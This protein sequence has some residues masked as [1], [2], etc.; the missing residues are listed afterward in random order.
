[1]RLVAGN[2]GGRAGLACSWTAGTPPQYSPF[3]RAEL[4]LLIA[5]QEW[6]GT[7]AECGLRTGGA[8][9]VCTVCLPLRC[10]E[11]RK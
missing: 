2:E 1:V 5:Q 8:L 6:L 10:T 7:G 11:E 4:G 9:Q 3:S